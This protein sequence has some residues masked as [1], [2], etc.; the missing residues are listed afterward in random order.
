MEWWVQFSPDDKKEGIDFA[1]HVDVSMRKMIVV[2]FVE[3][4][5]KLYKL[6]TLSK[7]G[8]R[9]G[10]PNPHRGFTSHNGERLFLLGDERDSFEERLLPR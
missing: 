3:D 1:Y 2:L 4:S 6:S 10:C 7:S 9:S 8:T 5:A